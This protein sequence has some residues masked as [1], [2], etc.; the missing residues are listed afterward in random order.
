MNKNI[1]IEYNNKTY[2]LEYNRR[3]VQQMESTGF[4]IS[5]LVDKP[6]TNLPLLFQG[7]FL[8]HH[9]FEKPELINEIYDSLTDKHGLITALAEL[10]NEP[11]V[12]L[13]EDSDGTKNAT[14]TASW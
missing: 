8:M 10:Y 12:T 7:A 5:E 11:L 4:K 9:R 14:W 13:L 2:T 1:T 3:T 6:A